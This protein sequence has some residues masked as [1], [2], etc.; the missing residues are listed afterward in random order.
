MP[1]VKGLLQEAVEQIPHSDSARLDAEVILGYVLNRDRAWIYTWPD[2]RPTEE[3]VEY[4]RDLIQRRAAGEPVAYLTGVREFW[5]MQL[6]CDNST[7][8]PRPDTELL[9]EQALKLAL[10]PAAQ[11]LD[12]GTG[13]GAIALALGK[14]RPQWH[15]RG[16][17]NSAGAIAL[18][19]ANAKTH[20]IRNVKWFKGDWFQP[21][22]AD[23]RFDLI[24]SNPPY[25]AAENKHLSAGD[26]R[27]EPRSA[28]VSG[29]D[30]LD[31]IRRLAASAGHWL[32]PRGWILL[33]HGYD[34][35]S[36][37]RVL[38]EANGFNSVQNF[39]DLAGHK[40]A[41]LGHW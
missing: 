10:P 35:A 36:E 16:T 18:A 5:G 26:V 8:I 33:E 21:L 34:Q 20:G 1:T 27:F 9:V 14:E 4:F 30:G 15:I 12:L 38:L 17:D 2:K 39:R 41:T 13:T 29:K 6:A 3:L 28:L 24:I 23:V 32:N 40:R 7:L 22:D 37:V 11:V 25:I 31:A 19:R